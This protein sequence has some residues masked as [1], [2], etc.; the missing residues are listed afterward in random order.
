MQMKL[1]KAIDK[2]IESLKAEHDDRINMKIKI[3]EQDLKD[4]SSLKKS[5]AALDGKHRWTATE[6]LDETRK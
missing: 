3:F 5:A 1:K 2:F 6:V 4:I